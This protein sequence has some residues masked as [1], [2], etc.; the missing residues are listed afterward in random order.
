MEITAQGISARFAAELGR[1][2]AFEVTDRGGRIAPLHRA[3]W[4]GT[5]EAMPPDAAP[6]MAGLGGDFFCAPFARSDGESPLHGWP[7]NVPWDIALAAPDRVR[8]VCSRPVFGATLLKEL[9]VYDNHPFVY[10]R[11]VFIGGSGRVSAANHGNVSVPHGAHIRTSAKIHWETPATAQETDPA[12][13]R[14]YIA[15]PARSDDAAAFPTAQG[16]TV[17]L[18]TYPWFDRSEDFAIGIEAEGSPL[19][20]TAV[21][22]PQ[23]G[24]LYLS[25]RHPRHLPMTML[26]Q[27]N[28]GRDYAPWSGRHT[29][30]LGVEDGAA[31]HMLGLSTEADLAGPGALALSPFGSTEM[32]HV[33]GAIAWPT[34]SPV[35]EITIAPEGLIVVGADGASRSLPLHTDFLRLDMP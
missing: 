27:S 24:D 13:G 28:G 11:H 22:R 5:G 29:G 12:K 4:V 6:L 26:W 34:G 23:E 14:S 33:T 31:A 9:A 16:G 18:T 32:R 2:D 8:A 7:P 20:W 15:C 17:D 35:A 19:G 25:L 30:C 10:Q 21:T 3:P 1:L